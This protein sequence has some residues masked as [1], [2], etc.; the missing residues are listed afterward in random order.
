[1][2]EIST[3]TNK[4]FFTLVFYSLPL[5]VALEEIWHNNEACCS[6]LPQ[7]LG[8]IRMVECTPY[9]VTLEK[10]IRYMKDVELN[11]TE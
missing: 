5:N 7:L 4:L 1:M 3:H 11:V 6:F 2:N 9:E 8:S 10:S